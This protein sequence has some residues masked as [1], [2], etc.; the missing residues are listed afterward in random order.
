MEYFEKLLI[1]FFK[2]TVLT[3]IVFMNFIEEVQKMLSTD[4]TPKHSQV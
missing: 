3:K 1:F 4:K 2:L